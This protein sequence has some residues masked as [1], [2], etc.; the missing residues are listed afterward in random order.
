LPD[1]WDLTVTDYGLEMG[2][3]RVVKEGSLEAHIRA[4]RNL[5][6]KPVV[7]VGRYTSPES[8]LA[9]LKSGAADFVGAARPSIAD[10]FLPNKIAEGR[11][12]DIRECIGCNI[13]YSSNSRHVPIRCT[14]NPTMGEE[15]R[16]DWH[17]EIIPAAR[18]RKRLLIVGGGPA[19][20]EAARAL[21]ERGHEVILTEARREFG[22]RVSGESRLPGLAEWARVRDWRLHQIGKLPQISLYPESPMTADDIV[23]VAADHILLATGAGWRKDGRGRSN[24]TA[25]IWP[26]PLIIH[27]V[28]DILAGTLPDGDVLVYDDDW[29]Y[30]AAQI[31]HHLTMNG[32][33]VTLATS[34]SAIA[35]WMRE[36]N[37]LDQER[38]LH[39]LR[40]AGANLRVNQQ[41][42]IAA[43]GH[44]ALLCTITGSQEA[45][46][47]KT[48]VPVT[49]REPVDALYSCLLADGRA[50]ADQVT[51]I[52][53]C[54][55]P[56][57]IADAVYSGHLFARTFDSE[58]AP[59]KRDRIVIGE[60]A[61]L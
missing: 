61:A 48:I 52:G 54:L 33:R 23:D 36:S 26:Q 1:L 8:M 49:E 56:S 24:R 17:P 47:A 20:L 46:R 34:A 32:C 14:Q 51:R 3:S 60:A 28:D 7:T 45:V 27:G 18:H 4:T 13:C 37:G 30:M 12:D 38:L 29:Y 41:L 11:L 40:S 55:R 42:D 19:G 57:I 39:D 58:T 5:T 59:V 10:P 53:D 43:D 21:G 15:W 6:S 2:L 16:R 9:L 22:G 25:F 31:A 50:T 35:A 44:L